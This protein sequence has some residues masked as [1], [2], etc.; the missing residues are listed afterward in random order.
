[1]H[2][3]QVTFNDAS[4]GTLRPSP[5]VNDFLGMFNGMLSFMSLSLYR[6]THHSH[7][8]YLATERDEEL[9]PFVAPGMP[10]WVRRLCAAIELTL[11]I[12][13]T[14]FLF[15]RSFVRRGSTLRSHRL[16]AR[17]AAEYVLITVV[18]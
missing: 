13:Y 11:G 2:G 18:W 12:L 8:A 17:V 14:P 1:M 3:H 16:R 10:R 5:R 15:L 7:H 9:W 4:H 6:A